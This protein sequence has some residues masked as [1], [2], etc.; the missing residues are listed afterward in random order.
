M[1]KHIKR[2]ATQL[3]FEKKIC[4][5]FSQE[6]P[7]MR[8]PGAPNMRYL[9]LGELSFLNNFNES[10]LQ[11]PRDKKKRKQWD[12]NAMIRAVKAVRNKEMGYLM[13]SKTFNVPKG[14]P[15]FLVIV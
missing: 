8:Y 10:C 2:V 14:K 3:I 15:A 9:I 5:E 7:N 4:K 1:F 12:K 6:I 11:M 13:A